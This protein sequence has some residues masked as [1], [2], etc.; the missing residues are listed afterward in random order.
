M[1]RLP[2]LLAALPVLILL[3]SLGTWQLQ[4]LHWKNGLLARIAAAE[5][6]PAVPLGDAPE[7]FAKV[8]ATGRFDHRRE[9][10]LGLE[11]R[12]PVLGARLVT[13]LLREGQAA[14]LVDR[15]WVP[16]ERAAPA[17]PEGEVMV[18]G[19]VHPG[20][21]PG[22]FAARDDP[23]ARRFYTFDPP[24]IGAALGLPQVAPHAIV[25]LGPPGS[26]DPARALPRPTNNHL[27]YAIT[28]YGLALALAGVA[29]A[30]LFRRN[31]T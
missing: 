17:R 15:G 28:W 4:R 29:A 14:I 10:L 23:A 5:A 30:L 12:G 22:L 9:S 21:R 1:R 2:L 16:L 6:A 27:G 26:P 31:P 25:A 18:E 24:A 20:D 13:P 8:R 3:V 11:T 7:P 19:F